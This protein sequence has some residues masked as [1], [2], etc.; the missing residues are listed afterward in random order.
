[1]VSNEHPQVIAIILSVLEHAVAADVLSYLPSDIRPEIVQRVGALETVQP[2]AMQELEA[3]MKKQFSNNSSARSSN[4]GGVQ[5]AAKIMN[6]AKVEMETQVMAGLM[7]LDE[8]MALQIQDQMFTFD[9]LLDVD[10]KAIQVIMRNVDQD[11]LMTGLKG[12]SDAVKE[13]FFDNMSARARVM[14]IDDMEA[15]GPMRVTDVEEAQKNIMRTAR[16][17]SDAGEL[18]LAGGGGD[19]FV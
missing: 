17:L 16:K 12:A 7:G 1:M 8:E 18:V 13:K 5:A 11:L 15:K 3:I 4:V 14:F 19:G 9:N 2:A 10:N 6:F